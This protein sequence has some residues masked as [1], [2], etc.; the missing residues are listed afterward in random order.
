M[1]DILSAK[2]LYF[3]VNTIP[4]HFLFVDDTYKIHTTH[5]EKDEGKKHD[6]FF[7]SKMLND[8]RKKEPMLGHNEEFANWIWKKVYTPMF[9]L[10]QSL[11]YLDS[12]RVYRGVTDK[13]CVNS[14]KL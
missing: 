12:R 9:S 13:I 3:C 6:S 10:S 14:I 8:E 5:Y 4:I 1:Y 7:S 11:V 2:Y